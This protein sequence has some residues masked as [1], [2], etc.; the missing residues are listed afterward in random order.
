MILTW[1]YQW[2]FRD[3]PIL[4]SKYLCL[5][6]MIQ[7]DKIYSR[8]R[9]CKPCNVSAEVFDVWVQ[10]QWVWLDTTLKEGMGVINLSM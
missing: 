6:T 9:A 4:Q 2:I 5:S 7:L 10:E 8:Q 3:K 1:D